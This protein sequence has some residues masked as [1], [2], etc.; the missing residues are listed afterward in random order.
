MHAVVGKRQYLFSVR[1]KAANLWNYVFCVT[2]CLWFRLKNYHTLPLQG[3]IN[4]MSNFNFFNFTVQI[5][6]IYRCFLFFKHLKLETLNGGV[7]GSKR[8]CGVR[9][10][11]GMNVKLPRVSVGDTG[12]IYVP[13]GCICNEKMRYRYK[14][15]S[16]IL[17]H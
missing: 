1:C 11:C 6:R 8:F 15:V 12:G 10:E 17:P 3:T 9:S 14:F 7:G 2:V 4:A 13:V 5:L 16:P